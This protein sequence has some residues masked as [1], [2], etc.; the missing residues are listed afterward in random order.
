M[1]ATDDKVGYVEVERREDMKAPP[2][3]TLASGNVTLLDSEG[4]VRRI[5]VPSS[6]P[7]D[8]LNMHKWRKCGILVACCWYSI[9]SLVLVGGAGPI[10]PFWIQEYSPEGKDPEE[11]VKLT[12]Y[13]SLVMALGKPL[14][15]TRRSSIS[16]PTNSPAGAFLILP[17]SMVFGRRPILLG[18]TILLLG[19]VV[20]AGVSQSY[21]THMAC[22]IL[23]G[24]AAGAT[25]SVST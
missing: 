19:S 17:L 21:N 13:P 1:S 23:Q 10:L 16:S 20:G 22:R 25:E 8:P 3:D 18:C 24:I 12:T 7:N 6:D 15:I 11:I 4:N 9:F 14:P 2:S 5:P